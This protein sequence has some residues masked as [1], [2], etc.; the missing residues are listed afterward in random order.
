MR[1]LLLDARQLGKKADPE[2]MA[3][4]TQNQLLIPAIVITVIVVVLAFL[5]WRFGA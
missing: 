4:P 5:Y 3:Q 2:Q 1:D